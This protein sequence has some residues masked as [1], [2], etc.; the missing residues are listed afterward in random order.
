MIKTVSCTQTALNFNAD[1]PENREQ[2]ADDKSRI[3]PNTARTRIRQSSQKIENAFVYYPVRGLQGNVNSDFYEFLTM[4]IVPYVLGSA[5]FM[6]IFNTANKYLNLFEKEKASVYGKKMALGVILYG[7][8]KNISKKPVTALVRHATG[9]DTEMPYQHIVYSL[10]TEAGIS[11]DVDIKHQ[12]R[13]VYDSKEFF[14]KDLLDKSYF[15]KVANKLGLGNNLNDSV[16]EVAPIIQNIVSTTNTAKSLSSYCWAGVGVGL[17]VQD[18]W[19]D[20]FNAISNRS[21]FFKDKD[22]GFLK[23]TF[24]RVKNICKNTWQITSS[25]IKLFFKSFGQMWQGKQG[26]RGF[27]KN[28]GKMFIS[29]ALLLTSY[30]TLNTIVRAK[31]MAKNSNKDT[32]DRT[33]ESTVI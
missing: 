22:S 9:V 3:L 30:L 31:K 32:I 5:T 23:N 25:F 8:M 15:D 24:G 6:F 28:S 2:P 13:K 20:F 33:K 16:S 10:P 29:L 12:H 7:I 11:A 27:A 18:C 21:R 26:S 19:K 14:R 4:G 17:A 1:K